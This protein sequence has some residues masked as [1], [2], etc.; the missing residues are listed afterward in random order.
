MDPGPTHD[1]DDEARQLLGEDPTKPKIPKNL[2]RPELLVRWAN[3]ILN[4]LDENTKKEIYEKYSCEKSLAAQKLNCELQIG[5]FLTDTAIKKDKYLAI[6][7]DQIGTALSALGHAISLL[8]TNQ[9]PDLRSTLLNSLYD[10][11]KILCDI[12]HSQLTGRRACILPSIRNLSL[13]TVLQDTTADNYVFGN[14]LAEKIKEAKIFIKMGNELKTP[15]NPTSSNPQPASK[16][17]NYH[18]PPPRQASMH[19]R[20]VGFNY[21]QFVKKTPT[22]KNS[23]PNQYH[24]KKD[25]RK[26]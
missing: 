12:H 20:Q 10:T 14:N 4:P 16:N 17:L 13:K 6:T 23:Q 22:K 24:Q 1:L 7:Q 3:W 11:G 18:R 2:I 9:E 8:L 26:R 19:A 5:K 15:L 25:T 21:K